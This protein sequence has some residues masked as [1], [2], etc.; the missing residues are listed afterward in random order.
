MTMNIPPTVSL[1]QITYLTPT[2]EKTLHN[3]TRTKRFPM[4]IGHAIKGSKMI[5]RNLSL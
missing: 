2:K 5:S 1:F 3:Q 4:Q